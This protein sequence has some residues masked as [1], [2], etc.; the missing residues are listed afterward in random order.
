MGL[1]AK[2][3]PPIFRIASKDLVV[4]KACT[5]CGLCVKNCPSQNIFEKNNRIKFGMSC[6][7]CMRCVYQCPQKAISYRLFKF[8][9]VPGGYN[10]RKTLQNPC[11]Y[12]E[13]KVKYI[14]PFFKEYIKNDAL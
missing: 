5:H 10:I 9:M 4:S 7:T 8:F 2:I 12:D 13:K 1:I 6:N 11:P 14:P 3:A